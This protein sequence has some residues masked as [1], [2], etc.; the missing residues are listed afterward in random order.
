VRQGEKGSADFRGNNVGCSFDSAIVWL[1]M[2]D[3]SR[4]VGVRVTEMDRC[5]E[6]GCSTLNRIGCWIP[7]WVAKLY[8]IVP[9]GSGRELDSRRLERST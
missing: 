3:E 9:D 5:V 1:R 8:S 2:L 4:L 7:E 6:W